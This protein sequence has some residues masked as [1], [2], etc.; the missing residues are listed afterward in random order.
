MLV[1]VVVV[2]I[3]V[4]VVYIY[5]KHIHNAIRFPWPLFLLSPEFVRM[6]TS[7]WPLTA[8][9]RQLCSSSFHHHHHLTEG[10]GLAAARTS[11][12]VS[13]PMWMVSVFC[14]CGLR[15]L[16]TSRCQVVLYHISS[17]QWKVDC[18]TLGLNKANCDLLSLL[19]DGKSECLPSKQFVLFQRK[20]VFH[21]KKEWVLLVKSVLLS[22][23][24]A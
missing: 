21:L 10:L 11:V 9:K 13:L 7:K 24:Q 5:W 20:V 4:V 16:L 15:C 6:M 12:A 3:D 17:S 19:T 14:Q 18:T 8:L 23:V 2:V 22:A 1:V